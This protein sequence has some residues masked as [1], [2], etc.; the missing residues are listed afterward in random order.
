MTE[1]EM[2]TE[3]PADG[4]SSRTSKAFV[5]AAKATLVSGLRFPTKTPRVP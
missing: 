4:R 3:L 1:I 5:E 2:V